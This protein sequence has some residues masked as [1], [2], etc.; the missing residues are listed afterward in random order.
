MEIYLVQH[1]LL[2]ICVSILVC[3]PLTPDSLKTNRGQLCR[4]LAHK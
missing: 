1:L 3:R 2:A 4:Q